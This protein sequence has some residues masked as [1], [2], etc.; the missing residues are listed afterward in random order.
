MRLLAALGLC[1]SLVLGSPVLSRV[2]GAAPVTPRSFTPTQSFTGGGTGGWSKLG[3]VG[4]QHYGNYTSTGQ[5]GSG[6]SYFQIAGPGVP[7]VATF[8]RSDGTALTGIA[9]DT[10]GQCGSIPITTYC[11]TMELDGT[12][13]IAHAH[14]E[15][16]VQHGPGGATHPAEEF[17]MRGTL[18]LNR[19]MGYAMVDAGGT[20]FAFGGID[21]LGDAHTSQACD[22]E[23][24]PSREGYWIVNTAGQLYAFGDAPYLGNAAV[25]TFSAAEFVISMSATPTGK[26]YWLFTSIGRALP[27]GDAHFFGDLRTY[28]LNGR[29]VGSVSTPTGNG[30]YMV[31]SDGGVFAFGD[32]RFRG[33]MGNQHLNQ[34]VVGLVPTPDNTGYWLVATDGGVFSFNATFFGSMGGTHLNRSVIA[35]V[36]YG[37]AYLM[38]ATD[39]GVFDFARAPFFGSQANAR[40]TTPIVS[41]AGGG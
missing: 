35:M 38:V 3:L 39:G 8:T 7:R 20:T 17:L 30:Y 23:P 28:T 36:P 24:T 41:A 1:V 15:V 33:S 13:D 34:P 25:S 9:R 31:G 27:F 21:H 22:L 12:S 18:T 14:I 11:F 19:R 37:N 2:A 10:A 4:L 29:I 6:V 26:G 32:A 40:L 16:V 5:L